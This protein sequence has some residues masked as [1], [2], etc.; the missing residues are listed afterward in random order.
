M[1]IRR[2]DICEYQYTCPDMWAPRECLDYDEYC[3]QTNRKCRKERE[4]YERLRTKRK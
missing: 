1:R 4:E 3:A 2:C